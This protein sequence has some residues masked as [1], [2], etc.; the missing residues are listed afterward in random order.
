MVFACYKLAILLEGTHARSLAGKADKAMGERFHARSV[1]LF[2][3]AL[4]L[5]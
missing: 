2:E 5:L 4:W 3:R 1:A